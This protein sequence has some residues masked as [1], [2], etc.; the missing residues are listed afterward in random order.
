MNLYTVIA[1][2]QRVDDCL[3]SRA[4]ALFSVCDSVLSNPHARTLR[5]AFFREKVAQHRSFG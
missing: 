3:E 4:N 2:C 1:S 5:V